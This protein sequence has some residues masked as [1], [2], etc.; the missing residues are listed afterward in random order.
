VSSTFNAN[1]RWPR[2]RRLRS[3][4]HRGCGDHLHLRSYGNLTGE[5]DPLT[6]HH[7]MQLRHAGA[8]RHHDPASGGTTTSTYD[9]W[10][11]YNVA[12]PLGR[13]TAYVYDANGNKTSATDADGT[14]TATSRM[15]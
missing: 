10:A 2:R 9:A 13:N 3:D 4:G 12:A 6:P 8:P 7:A 11:S 1:A 5:T 14:T 15:R